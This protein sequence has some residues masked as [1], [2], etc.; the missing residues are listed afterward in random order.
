MLISNIT[1]GSLKQFNKFIVN[2]KIKYL[3][4]LGATVERVEL[5]N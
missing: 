3:K 5:A 1:E 4:R 2:A